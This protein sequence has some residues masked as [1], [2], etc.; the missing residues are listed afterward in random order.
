MNAIILEN[1]YTIDPEILGLVKDNPKVFTK[2][3]DLIGFQMRGLDEFNHHLKSH[4]AIIAASTFLDKEQ[5]EDVTHLLTKIKGKKIF[6]HRFEDK[7]ENWMRDD[8]DQTWLF[9][10]FDS[11][12]ANI[13]TCFQNHEVYS[14]S[15]EMV[16]KD[17]M[18]DEIWE[19]MMMPSSVGRGK[20]TFKKLEL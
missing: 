20:I 9:H 8:F 13:K 14:F 4:E 16:T 3:T 17:G 11:F 18:K 19:S 5:L 15:E 7:V 2:T 10:D 1:Q 12:K 6:I